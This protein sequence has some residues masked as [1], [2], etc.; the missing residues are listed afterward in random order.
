MMLIRF[1]GPTILLWIGLVILQNLV[2]TFILFY[3][4]LLILPLL[5]KVPIKSYFKGKSL[6]TWFMG[7]GIGIGFFLFVYVGL[8]LLKKDGIN[9]SQ[10]NEIL[11]DWGFIGK[12]KWWLILF[13]VFL[14]PIL[15]ELYWRGDMQNR[16]FGKYNL[17]QTSLITSS[18]YSLYH[19][20]P[21]MF[22]FA[23]PFSVIMV[24][25]VF[26]AGIF[27]SF[28]SQKSGTIVGSIVSH[29]LADLAIIIAY[30]YYLQ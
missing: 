3:G 10:M 2:L 12:T 11:H 24:I 20:I 9:L 25:P 26:L 22:L 28:Y 13:L 19:L 15:E 16:L 29:S 7:L 8:A 23:F 1:F 17:L 30:L 21:L 5:S 4:W 27:W 14:N 6:R 18:F